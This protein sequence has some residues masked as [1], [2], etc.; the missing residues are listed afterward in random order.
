[1]EKQT[2][3][4]SLRIRIF[5]ICQMG[6]LKC[7]LWEC[8]QNMFHTN[9][10]LVLESGKKIEREKWGKDLILFCLFYYLFPIP[11]YIYKRTIF[12]QPGGLQWMMIY[13][14]GL[15]YW[16]KT[17]EISSMF[18]KIWKD[19]GKQYHQIHPYSNST[20]GGQRYCYYVSTKHAN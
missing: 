13:I 18:H 16:E 14:E 15:H 11:P 6:V 4:I 8:L 17:P 20:F 7:I 19:K 2:I 5:E 10:M 3:P 12:R 9:A 1:M